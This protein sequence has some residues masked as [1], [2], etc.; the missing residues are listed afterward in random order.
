MCHCT[1][2]PHEEVVGQEAQHRRE[3]DAVLCRGIKADARAVSQRDL[4]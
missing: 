3:I 1:M 2:R 4:H